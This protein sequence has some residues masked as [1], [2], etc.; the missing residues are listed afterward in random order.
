MQYGQGFEIDCQYL[1][2]LNAFI[3]KNNMYAS[4]SSSS[5]TLPYR[6]LGPTKQQGQPNSKQQGI[7]LQ[8]QNTKFRRKNNQKFLPSTV[9]L[10]R[11]CRVHR[12]LKFSFQWI[13]LVLL[14]SL[15]I[16]ENCAHQRFSPLLN[17]SKLFSPSSLSCCF[18]LLLH[19][20]C[21]CVIIYLYL[22]CI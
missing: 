12:T 8:I 21:S 10:R 5:S 19:V 7:W 20:W 13:L 22:S 18:S 1:F 15:A 11:S 2:I 14:F 16:A 3:T 6:A 4:S 17:C 9:C